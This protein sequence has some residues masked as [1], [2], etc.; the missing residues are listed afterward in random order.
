M[1]GFIM[2][3][4][5]HKVYIKLNN[6]KHIVASRRVRGLGDAQFKATTNTQYIHDKLGTHDNTSTL[7]STEG[8]ARKQLKG[9]YS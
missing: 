6:C 9:F 3:K 4:I 2:L 5:Y 7:T 1:L 8:K